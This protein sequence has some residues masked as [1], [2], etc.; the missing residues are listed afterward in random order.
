MIPHYLNWLRLTF[1][2][3]LFDYLST[4][5]FIG[6]YGI[7]NEANPV[8]KHAFQHGYSPLLWVGVWA[9]IYLVIKSTEKYG[10]K[11]AEQFRRIFW[12]MWGLPM[13]YVIIDY[14]HLGMWYYFIFY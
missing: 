8:M 4:A 1:S 3:S 9:F 2:L 12:V 6:L 13:I 14:M 10:R 11:K 5:F 7:E